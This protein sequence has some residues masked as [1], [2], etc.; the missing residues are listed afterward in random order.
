M[1]WTPQHR[2]LPNAAR[3]LKP[4]GRIISLIKPHYEAERSQIH[5]GVLDPAARPQV[6]EQVRGRIE[7]LGM[8]IAGVVESPL[9]GQKGNIEYL[10]LIEP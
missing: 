4:G 5:G 9:P 6:L 7:G 3:L 1:A 8:K 10:A 2:I